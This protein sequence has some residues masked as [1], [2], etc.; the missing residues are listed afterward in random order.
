MTLF[1]GLYVKVGIL[2]TLHVESIC[3]TASLREP[4][5][6]VWTHI[7]VLVLIQKSKRSSI[8]V[9]RVKYLCAKGQ[10]FVC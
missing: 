4:M 1:V 6:L 2:L 3:M 9:L 8:C 5:K 7:E 10:V